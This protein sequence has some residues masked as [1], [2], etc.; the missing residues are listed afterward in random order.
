MGDRDVMKYQH[1]SSDKRSPKKSRDTIFLVLIILLAQSGSNPPLPLLRPPA[2]I[3]ALGSCLGD[4][5]ALCSIGLRDS[6]SRLPDTEKSFR[7][8]CRRRWRPVS[9]MLSVCYS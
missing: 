4:V 2:K 5:L 8:R 3:W 6:R 9:G 1:D 7:T